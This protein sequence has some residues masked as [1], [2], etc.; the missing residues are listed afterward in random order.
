MKRFQNKSPL[1]THIGILRLTV[2]TQISGR[3]DKASTTETI[4]AGLIL[5]RVKS[6]TIKI[7]VYSFPASPSAIKRLFE[8]SNVLGALL[9]SVQRNS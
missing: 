1:E 9:F 3:V 8:V 7:N 4:G 2:T 5:G 6:K